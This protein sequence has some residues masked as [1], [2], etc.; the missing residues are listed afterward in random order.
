MGGYGPQNIALPRPTM[1][2]RF[3]NLLQFASFLCDVGPECVVT[4]NQLQSGLYQYDVGLVCIFLPSTVKK[5][6]I[7]S[8]CATLH[9]LDI[10]MCVRNMHIDTFD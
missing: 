10:C 5:N 3:V 6:F 4:V 9:Y 1:L 8:G 2:L 7:A